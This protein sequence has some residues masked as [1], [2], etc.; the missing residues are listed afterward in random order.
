MVVVVNLERQVLERD[1]GLE[2]LEER[3]VVLLLV[4][5]RELQVAGKTLAG[6]VEVEETALLREENGAWAAHP[7]RD[8]LGLEAE[9]IEADARGSLERGRGIALADA[10]RAKLAVAGDAE[11]VRD[12]GGRGNGKVVD[13]E[14]DVLGLELGSVRQTRGGEGQYTLRAR[15]GMSP[16][17]THL[18]IGIS[19][20]RL[21]TRGRTTLTA[22]L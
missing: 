2:N 4:S 14:L 12:E 5:E 10:R 18:G 7:E 22:S 19:L 16:I 9:A 3:L 1:I 17:T 13:D 8:V 11:I 15:D 6:K 21:R 20:I